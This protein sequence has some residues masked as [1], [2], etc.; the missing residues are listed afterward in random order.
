MFGLHI[1]KTYGTG[2]T[3]VLLT[4]L[5]QKAGDRLRWDETDRAVLPERCWPQTPP[6][7]LSVSLSFCI[8][9]PFFFLKGFCDF[10]F[11]G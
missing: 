7:G 11:P 10:F 8:A 6:A 3:S 4:T 1:H 5:Q 2:R 9:L